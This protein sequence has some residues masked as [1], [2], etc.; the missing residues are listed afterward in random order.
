MKNHTD[1]YLLKKAEDS[2]RHYQ[3]TGLHVTLE[4]ANDWMGKIIASEE[5]GRLECHK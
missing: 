3:E 4:E 5:T 2:W 1:G